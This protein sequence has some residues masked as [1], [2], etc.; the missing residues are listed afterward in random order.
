MNL[1]FNLLEPLVL[2]T[3]EDLAEFAVMVHHAARSSTHWRAAHSRSSHRWLAHLSALPTRMSLRRRRRATRLTMLPGLSRGASLAASHSHRLSRR[4]IF[5]IFNL[6]FRQLE[7]FNY[8]RSKQK[9]RT[10]RGSHLP[11]GHSGAA[12]ASL[13]SGG[14]RTIGP[15]R[16]LRDGDRR[17][18]GGQGDDQRS[19]IH[20]SL[21]WKGYSFHLQAH[22]GSEL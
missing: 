3:A 17:K 8:F 7:F 15:P 21:L 5:N 20:H 10:H 11:S 4:E 14:R 22:F 19:A 16:L 12:L 2:R 18:N 13:E 1:Q 6:L 9:P